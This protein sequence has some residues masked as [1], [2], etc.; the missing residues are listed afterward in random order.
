MRKSIL[1]LASLVLTA[2]ATAQP[3]VKLVGAELEAMIQGYVVTAGFNPA[4]GC[5]F[6]A[7][8]HSPSRREQYADCVQQAGLSKGSARIDGDRLCTK[9]EYR[10][11]RC[12][13]VY[14]VGDNRFE[15]RG[16]DGPPILV[17]RLR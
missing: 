15:L 5:V 9:Y 8:N 2:A 3:G 14:R 12:T 1:A 11:E 4:N 17:Y 13:E 6:M 16:G 7:V 10:D